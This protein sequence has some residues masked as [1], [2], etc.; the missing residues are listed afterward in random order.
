MA[1]QPFYVGHGRKKEQYIGSEKNGKATRWG[2]YWRN[3]EWV[4]E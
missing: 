2:V 1:I 4:E 3:G